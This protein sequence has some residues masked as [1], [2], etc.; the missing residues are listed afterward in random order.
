[1]EW[2]VERR[3]VGLRKPASAIYAYL[4][5]PDNTAEALGPPFQAARRLPDWRDPGQPRLPN[6][7]QAGERYECR[8]E[9]A[10]PGLPRVSGTVELEVTHARPPHAVGV[11]ARR[12]TDL[13][14]SLPF[15]E[16]VHPAGQAVHAEVHWEIRE[17]RAPDGAVET[18]L[19]LRTRGSARG[20]PFLERL[21]TQ[22][23]V[24]RHVERILRRL[25]Q[26]LMQAAPAAAPVPV[27]A[28]ALQPA[29]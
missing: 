9:L 13:R 3:L 16:I 1:M 29:G 6:G 5:D 12:I 25:G 27:T 10:L 23:A 4:T 15:M 24:E 19:V 8:C 14:I 20:L 18:F 7:M 26:A 17:H 28:P 11:R 22:R 2:H 21:L